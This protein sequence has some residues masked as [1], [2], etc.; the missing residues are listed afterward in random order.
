MNSP[1]KVGAKATSVTTSK[2]A[3]HADREIDAVASTTTGAR[4]DGA[5]PVLRCDGT[6]RAAPVLRWDRIGRAPHTPSLCST[7]NSS[8]GSPPLE[9]GDLTEPGFP[10]RRDDTGTVTGRTDAVPP[11]QPCRS[12]LQ[13]DRDR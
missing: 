1:L 10:A 3:A 7:P 6:G 9:G 2:S 4:V 13:R 8:G 5:E 11:H 12:L